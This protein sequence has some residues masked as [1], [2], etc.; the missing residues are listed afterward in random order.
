ME[1]VH[2][3]ENRTRLGIPCSRDYEALRRS[4]ALQNRTLGAESWDASENVSGT[5]R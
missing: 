5:T 4:Y 2:Q 3:R 1:S